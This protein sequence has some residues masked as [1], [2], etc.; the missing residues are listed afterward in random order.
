MAPRVVVIG[1]GISGLAAAVELETC[2]ADV[3]IVTADDRAGGVMQSHRPPAAPGFLFEDGPNSVRGTSRDFRG[4]CADLGVASEIITSRPAASARFMLHRGVPVAMPTTLWGLLRTPLLPPLARLRF[5]DEWLVPRRAGVGAGLEVGSGDDEETVAAFVTRRFGSGAA[6]RLLDA[7]VAGG[8]AG[9]ATQM[10]MTSACPEL[11]AMERDHGSV[12]RAVGMVMRARRKASAPPPFLITLRDGLGRVGA[13][14]SAHFG[15]RLST[16]T[17]ANR[18]S[19]DGGKWRVETTCQGR[20]EAIET[21]RVVLA[22][23]APTTAKLLRPL[24]TDEEDLGAVGAIGATAH[25]GLAV[26]QVACAAAD[27]PRLPTGFG[28]LNPRRAG[29]RMLG[30]IFGSHVFEGRAPAGGLA[31]TGLVGGAKDPAALELDDTALQA[32][33]LR[34]LGAIGGGSGLTPVFCRIVRHRDAMPQ[35]NVGHA[36][37]V[38]AVMGVVRRSLPGLSLAGSWTLGAAVGRCIEQGRAAARIVGGGGVASAT[39][40]TP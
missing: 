2:G 38:R 32:L 11:V 23:S 13:A 18:L 37:R 22:V 15:A 20:S 3:R 30:W 39:A 21:D 6:S 1:A 16:S 28:V 5:L 33:A 36:A 34:E 29:H 9:D 12:L 40:R 25:A 10:G 4:L 7:I 14:A 27:L 19:R 26:V 24:I 35:F 8:W 31:L 17:S